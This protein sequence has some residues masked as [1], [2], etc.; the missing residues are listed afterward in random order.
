LEYIWANLAS[1]PPMATA[2]SLLVCLFW[3]YY[4]ALIFFLGAE[5]T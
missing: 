5:F 4:P 2:G 3:V 1:L